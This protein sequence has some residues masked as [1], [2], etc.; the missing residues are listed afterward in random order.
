M[1]DCSEIKKHQFSS[2]CFRNEECTLF[3]CLL[4]ELS[5]PL[6]CFK[7]FLSASWDLAYLVGFMCEMISI[8]IAWKK[9]Q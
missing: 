6:M 3:S 8:Q 2:Y 4:S 7:S 5:D 9:Q 1:C